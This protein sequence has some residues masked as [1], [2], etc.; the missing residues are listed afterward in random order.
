M[1]SE[2]SM[3]AIKAHR[4]KALQPVA[5]IL[6]NDAGE[7]LITFHSSEATNLSRPHDDALVLTLSVLNCEVSRI[8]VNNRSLADVLFLST[9]QEMEIDESEIEK[10]TTV[11]IGFNGKST[12]AVGKIKLPVFAFGENKMT[13]FLIM[14]CLSVYNIILGRP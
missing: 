14:D 10:S 1:Y 13:T 3:I 2:D 9:L 6:P 5:L 12:A 8:L 4:R 11:L 7:H